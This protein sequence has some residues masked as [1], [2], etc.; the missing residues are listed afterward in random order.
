MEVGRHLT[1][2]QAVEEVVSAMRG[3][4]GWLEQLKQSLDATNPDGT[5][6]DEARQQAY[7]I[8]LNEQKPLHEFFPMLVPAFLET[9]PYISSA[10]RKKI[11]SHF[12][13]KVMP[14]IRDFMGSHW[15]NFSESHPHKKYYKSWQ[16]MHPYGATKRNREEFLIAVAAGAQIP[17]TAQQD[18]EISAIRDDAARAPTVLK[19]ANFDLA[20][21]ETDLKINPIEVTEDG[22]KRPESPILISG[23]K[24]S[25]EIVEQIIPHPFGGNFE[26]SLAKIEFTQAGENI[27]VG[28]VT[29]GGIQ[30]N[31]CADQGGLVTGKDNKVRA[32]AWA[33]GVGDSFR[34]GC[35]AAYCAVKAALTAGMEAIGMTWWQ[36]INELRTYIEEKMQRGF[37]LEQYQKMA[38][39]RGDPFYSQGR[40][41]RFTPDEM[42]SSTIWMG[43]ISDKKLKIFQLGDGGLIVMKKDGQLKKGC[44]QF[45]ENIAPEQLSSYPGSRRGKGGQIHEIDLEDGDIV[46][47][48]TDGALKGE[49]KDITA[50]SD[51]V[52]QMICG[53]ASIREIVEK[54]IQMAKGKNTWGDDTLVMAF[55]V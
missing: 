30:I 27:A 45:V 11:L 12:L 22:S 14:N 3:F 49:W 4:L 46:V 7:D 19:T 38:G 54:V 33:D 9:F 26:P 52:G 29:E 2:R 44:G 40:G 50:F 1:E 23:C 10:H 16:Q 6:N 39:Q 28:R 35:D 51:G 13:D 24:S 55:R 48:V 41:R 31:L 43:A 36:D 20:S 34:C 53:G 17:K 5:P 21:I 25:R 15:C 18:K 47:A 32:F 37:P 8:L 42:G